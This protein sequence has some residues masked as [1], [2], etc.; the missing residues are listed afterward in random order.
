[1]GL[2]ATSAL[3]AL[4]FRDTTLLQRALTHRSY[5]NEHPE[6]GEDNERL[7]F[8]GDAVLDFVSGAWLYEQFPT[9]LEGQLTR[10]R[11]ALVRTEQL[12]EFAHQLGISQELRL[13]HGE[14]ESGGRTRP[15]LACAAMEAVI[16]AL[17]VDSGIDAVRAF[18]EPLLAEGAERILAAQAEVD[19]KSLLQEWAQSA[20]GLTPSYHTVAETG[21]DHAKSFRVEVRIG[22]ARWGEGVGP[23]KQTAAQAAAEA[24]LQTIDRQQRR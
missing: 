17:Y 5:V 6:A 22:Q 11:A 7:E 24:A 20:H 10:L 15:P 2:P 4:C 8:L 3:S 21:P 19:A 16:G 18:V 13:G 14:A 9:M 23:S 1:M 12:A